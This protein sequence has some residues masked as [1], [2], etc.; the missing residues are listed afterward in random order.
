MDTISPRCVALLRHQLFKPSE[1]FITE[2]ARALRSFAPLLVGRALE[3]TPHDGLEYH[4]PA[5]AGRMQRLNYV[6]R[7][8]PA[9]FFPALRLYRPVL[10]HAHF[11]VEA[12][13]GM[14]IAERLGVP[15][16]T[17]FH[18]FDATLSTPK[19]LASRKPSW[20]NYVLKRRE[21]SRRGT[22]FVCVSEFVRSRLL[23]LGFPEA[24]TRV[25]YIGVDSA[26]FPASV[27]D[28]ERPVILHVARLV[29]KKGTAYLLE[30]FAAISEK[31][32]Q[33]SLVIVGDGPLREK[34]RRH[35]AELRI[36]ERVLWVG[37]ASHSVVRSWLRRAS[38][39]CLPSCTA[40][41]GDSEGLP[42]SLLEANASGV[43]A[44]AT[45]HAGIPEAIIHGGTGLLV[46]ERDA[47]ALAEALD[48]LLSSQ[49]QREAFGARARQVTQDRFDLFRQTRTLEQLYE[50]VL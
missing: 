45:Q 47:A 46:R 17:T 36:G 43:A 3:G 41:N 42:I 15:L 40:L 8:D 13:Y 35:A 7:R 49:S 29:E 31:H 18:G 25:H 27:E 6:L 19:L 37:A 44:V 12:V 10:M 26:D 33:A 1:V 50:G 23:R 11:G 20:I 32:P 30:A 48:V 21:L 22:L 38:V 4:V 34:L 9:M 14:E 16:V 5:A 28:P 2:Q 39:F 24:R